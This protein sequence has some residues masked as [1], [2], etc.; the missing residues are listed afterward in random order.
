VDQQ[1]IGDELRPLPRRDWP[2]GYHARADA[3]GG[4][5]M[6][7]RPQRISQAQRAV[8][9]STGAQVDPREGTVLHVSGVHLSLEPQRENEPIRIAVHQRNFTRSES[10]RIRR[11]F[12][13]DLKYVISDLVD[14]L[15]DT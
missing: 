11:I 4:E 6:L 2:A 8:T 3:Q 13:S 7:L 9:L 12:A 5:R 14:V 1:R 15:T 10:T